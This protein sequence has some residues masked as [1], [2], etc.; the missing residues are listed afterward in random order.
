MRILPDL[1]Q[2]LKKYCT[3]CGMKYYLHKA[4][5][6]DIDNGLCASCTHEVNWLEQ[7]VG[8]AE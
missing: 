1:T 4:I 2:F 7:H 5:S 6:N 3:A 8:E